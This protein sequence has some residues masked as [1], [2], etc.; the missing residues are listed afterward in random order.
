MHDFSNL[1]TKK[2]TDM[3]KADIIN[4]LA[5]STGYDKKT[6]GVIVESFTESV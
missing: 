3:T 6:V 4:E 1:Y 5:L 2:N